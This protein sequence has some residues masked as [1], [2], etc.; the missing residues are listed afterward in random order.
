MPRINNSRV[1]KKRA[2]TSDFMPALPNLE[3]LKAA[4]KEQM[5][6]PLLQLTP[7]SLKVI[8]AQGAAI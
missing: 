1:Q 7:L 8:Q 3:H 6:N 4:G 2:Y 5:V